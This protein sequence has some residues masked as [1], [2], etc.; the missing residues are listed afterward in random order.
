MSRLPCLSAT[1]AILRA[2]KE[3]LLWHRFFRVGTV[4]PQA[5]ELIS[6]IRKNFFFGF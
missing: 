2:G 3:I 6:E 5:Y 4:L 1:R